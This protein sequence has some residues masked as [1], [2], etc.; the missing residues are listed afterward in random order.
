MPLK[1]RGSG[2]YESP[3]NT[4]GHRNG[5]ISYRYFWKF[6]E[7]Q[8][9]RTLV[10]SPLALHADANVGQG[11]VGGM[12]FLPCDCKTYARYCCRDSVCLSVRPSVCLS[13][14]RVY[15]DKTKQ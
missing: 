15:C 12:Q 2:N 1:A 6:L 3:C 8:F 7:F 11:A 10:F 14:K 9:N 4:F 5:K 13:V